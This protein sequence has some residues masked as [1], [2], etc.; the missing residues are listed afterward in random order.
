MA[1]FFDTSAFAKLY[2]EVGS[3]FIQQLLGIPGQVS[4]ISRLGAIEMHSVLAGKVRIGEITQEAMELARGRFLADARRRLF[5]VA[6]LRA[7]HFESAEKL[8]TLHGPSGLRTLDALQLAM[9]IDLQRNHLVESI[10]VADRILAQ[11]A[12]LEGLKVV[13][14]EIPEG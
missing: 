10:V 6:A 9:A 8:L 11:I 7:R 14:P 3:A 12:P 4:F 5:R 1:L 2:H 13:N